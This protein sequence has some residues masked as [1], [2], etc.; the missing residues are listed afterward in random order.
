MTQHQ[1]GRR[2]RRRDAGRQTGMVGVAA[3]GGAEPLQR[4]DETLRLRQCTSQVL[5]RPHREERAVGAAVRR[6]RRRRVAAVVIATRF[7]AGEQTIGQQRV[8][9]AAKRR[10]RPRQAGEVDEVQTGAIAEPTEVRGGLLD[11]QWLP[12]RR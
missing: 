10:P 7:D 11:G 3:V 12:A 2:R 1:D 4:L 6:R 9:L 8:R 5:I